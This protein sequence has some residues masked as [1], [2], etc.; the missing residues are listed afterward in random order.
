MDRFRIPSREEVQH[1]LCDNV[2]IAAIVII[3]I[4]AVC[5]VHAVFGIKDRISIIFHFNTFTQLTI[6]L[7]C[8]FLIPHV[9]RK[10]YHRYF[11][12]RHLCGFLSVFLL[13]PVFI[14]VFA[15]FKQT[16]PQIH[17]FRF[18]AVFM[19]LDYLIHFGRHPW[20]LLS[21]LL[22][23]PWII[24]VL[25]ALYM[26]WFVLLIV[27]GVWM[28]WTRRRRLRVRFFVSLLAIWFFLGQGMAVIFSSVGPCYFS[29]VVDTGEDPFQPLMSGLYEIHQRSPLWAIDNQEGL[30]AAMEEDMWLPFGGISAMPSIHLAIATLFALLAAEIRRWLGVIFV[31]YLGAIQIGS[32]ILGW[33]YAVDGYV[34]IILTCFIWYGVRRAAHKLKLPREFLGLMSNEA[35]AVGSEENPRPS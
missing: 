13:A 32:V 5:S 25:D 3:N 8:L 4:I 11:T 6:A 14:S 30:W 33:H 10:S 27:F 16:I 7:S 19:R 18:D 22:A 28:S 21:S 17:D 12:P 1:I 24:R 26:L 15:S 23:Y 29:K 20:Q 9:L 34:S 35:V 2:P 31:A